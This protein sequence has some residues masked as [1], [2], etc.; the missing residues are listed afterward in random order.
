MVH[1]NV[2]GKEYKGTL[3]EYERSDA[4][5]MPRRILAREMLEAQR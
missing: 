1:W 2:D 3:Q 4:Y 5:L